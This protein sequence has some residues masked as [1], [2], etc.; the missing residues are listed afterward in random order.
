MRYF[1]LVMV[2]PD[3]RSSGN[4]GHDCDDHR[5]NAPR[6]YDLGCMFR[7]MVLECANNN[8]D[9]PGNAG[10]GAAGV[11]ASEMLQETG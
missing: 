8:V 3:P 11:D 1:S 9:E 10:C 2:R 7:N 6:E 5:N 4:H